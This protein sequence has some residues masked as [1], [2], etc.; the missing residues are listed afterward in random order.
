MRKIGLLCLALVLALG[1][2]GVGYAAWT[3]SVTITGTVNTG[4]VD[5]VVVDHSNTTVWKSLDYT[6]DI[7]VQ[8]TWDNPGSD[9][10]NDP[11]PT[12]PIDAF[13]NPPYP[14]GPAGVD[15]V[16]T[17]DASAGASADA[18]VI[19]IDNAFPCTALTADFLLHYN[20]TIPVKVQVSNLGFVDDVNT[21]DD[22]IASYVTIN[23]WESNI[24]GDKVS[25]SQLPP[26]GYQ[27]H[28]CEYI[29]VEI[30]VHLDQTDTLQGQSGTING[31]IKVIQ[32]NKYVPS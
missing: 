26:L 2:L 25:P 3:D 6:D 29:L 30:T 14:P 17:A 23:Y 19:D 10:T 20:G 21:P 1:T 31:E 8:K 7:Y 16:A 11:A 13:P 27:F 32:W 5:L 18:I 12:N 4:T 28:Q 24:A 22:D 9:R 15:P